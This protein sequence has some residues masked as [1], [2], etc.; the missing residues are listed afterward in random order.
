MGEFPGEL[1]NRLVGMLRGVL[2]HLEGVFG[3]NQ[4]MYCRVS[5]DR[6]RV[7]IRIRGCVEGL[8]ALK[9]LLRSS[10]SSSSSFSALCSIQTVLAYVYKGHSVC[11]WVVGWVCKWKEG[12]GREGVVREYRRKS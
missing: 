6:I 3:G 7:T 8:G 10:H 12:G 9:D 11:K 5:M 1:E 2:G 4:E